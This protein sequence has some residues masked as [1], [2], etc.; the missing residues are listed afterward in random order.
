MTEQKLWLTREDVAE[1]FGV[2]VESVRY[3]E[4][5]GTGP[6]S[7]KFGRHIRYR[8]TDVEEWEKTRVR[9]AV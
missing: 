7:A 2:P 6:P 4:A 5:K 1:R 9:G 3:W 8:L